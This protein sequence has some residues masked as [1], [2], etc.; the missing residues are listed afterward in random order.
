MGKTK[1]YEHRA[2]YG[3]ASSSISENATWEVD[4]SEAPDLQHDLHESSFSLHLSPSDID[5]EQDQPNLNAEDL[6]FFN[7][8]A[9]EEEISESSSE[10]ESHPDEED[11]PASNQV[12]SALAKT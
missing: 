10:S 5:E 12:F 2:L 7:S 3:V 1:Y 11:L 6:Q 9:D 4:V 8:M